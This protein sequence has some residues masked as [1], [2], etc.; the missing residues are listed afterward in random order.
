MATFQAS[1]RP[2]EG[3]VFERREGFAQ[4]RLLERGVVKGLARG[5]L[6]ERRVGN[7]FFIPSRGKS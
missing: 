7:D 1:I 5:R 2:S 4:G 3:K 6:L